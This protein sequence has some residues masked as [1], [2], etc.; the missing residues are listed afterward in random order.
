MLDGDD[1]DINTH[2]YVFYVYVFYV[3]YYFI[4]VFI[5]KDEAL[6]PTYETV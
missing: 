1:I 3:F 6:F 4:C 5:S 2:F